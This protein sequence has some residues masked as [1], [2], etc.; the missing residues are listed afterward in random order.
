MLSQDF[1]PSQDLFLDCPAARELSDGRA[2]CAGIAVLDDDGNP[3]DGFSQG[4]NAHFFFEF[5]VFED[6]GIPSGGIQIR[7]SMDRVI[8]GKE[9]FLFDHPDLPPAAAGRRLRFHQVIKLDLRP[10]Q[11]FFNAGLA[12]ADES[13]YRAYR[14]KAISFLQLN[15]RISHPCLLL[16]AGTF[17]V[18]LDRSGQLLHHGLANLPGS[19]ELAVLAHG[20]A[21]APEP[22]SGKTD[23][24]LPAVFHVTHWK[25]GSQWIA[26]ILRQCVPDLIVQPQGFNEQFRIWPIAPGKVY[27]TVYVTREEF[28]SAR[29]PAQ[30]RRFVVI[31]DLRDTLVSAYFSFKISHPIL[32]PEIAWLRGELNRLEFEEGLIFLMKEWLHDCAEIQISW[33]ESGEPVIDYNDLLENDV[34]ILEKILLDQCLLPLPRERFREIVKANRFEKL[35]QG[36]PRGKENT[37]VHERKGIAGDWQNYFTDRIK[38]IFKARFGGV[39]VASGHEKDLS[40]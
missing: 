14:D 12:A 24:T 33:I 34:E 10:G 17:R 15:L 23:D 3:R 1:W 36:R 28:E 8:H 11:Y 26:N 29:L 25:A 20:Q 21:P 22:P 27:P 18:E 6:L 5:E 4:E 9:T 32:D 38:K 2:R 16:N 13:S 37:A 7:D 30:W 19:S 40:W 39:L 31:R 35:T